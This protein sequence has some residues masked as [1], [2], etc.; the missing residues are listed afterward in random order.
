MSAVWVTAIVAV[1]VSVIQAPTYESKARILA[2]DKHTRAA[3]LGTT[4]SEYNQA[5]RG[6]TTQTQLEG[7]GE[8]HQHAW[9]GRPPDELMKHATIS[10]VAQANIVSVGGTYGDSQTA[11]EAASIQ[12][13]SRKGREVLENVRHR[14][15]MI[16]EVR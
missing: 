3:L 8:R 4:I 2:S 7:T 15:L 10:V 5:E 14:S 16:S 11:M 6:L 9:A 1:V 12:T 13:A